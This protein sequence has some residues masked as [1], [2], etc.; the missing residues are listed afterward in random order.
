M[1]STQSSNDKT[2]DI[3]PA[4]IDPNR[5]KRARQFARIRRRL[6]LVDLTIVAAYV[7]SWL[8]FG[9][10]QNLA[11]ALA[12]FTSNEW[13]L[14]AAFGLVFGAG[15]FIISLPLDFYSGFV[16][17]HRFNIST[18]SLASWVSDL[19]KSL[20]LSALLGGAL[21]EIV[22]ALLRAY[23]QSWWLWVAGVLLL[24]TVIMANLAPV[25]ILPLFYKFKPL[26]EEYS[27][28][29]QRLLAL[30]ERTG[31]KV[32]GVYQ[33]DMSR[34]TTAANAGLTGL[35]NTRR[36]LL[37]DTLLEEFTPDEIETILA[38]ELGHH[39][40]K[41]IPVG[42]LVEST[43]TLVGLYLA[44]IGMALGVGW[45]GLNG[46]GDP[47]GMPL[48]ILVMGLYGLL[49]MPLTNAY[50]RWR[51]RRADRFALSTTHK[52][53]A[54]TSAL[55]RLANQNLSEVEPEP[56]VEW[57]LH[58]HPSLGKRIRMAREFSS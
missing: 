29:A 42:I 23:P 14:V 34:R 32:E 38:H 11:S 8:I 40:H 45:L 16:L 10:S 44:S 50:S 6:M 51:E 41:D 46:P 4:T 15:Y 52:V 22:Y 5:Q 21:L 1:Q 36:I 17:P 56:W 43:I 28:L 55:I 3:G 24:I 39:V 37:G 54:Y 31:T 48:L 7:L 25:I 49:T 18:Q 57:L 33:F 13:L 12:G 2:P 19:L 26:D 47:A 58:S 30:A 20:G 9:W 53:E 27:E 35:G